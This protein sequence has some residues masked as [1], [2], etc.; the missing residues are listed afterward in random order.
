MREKI[1][2]YIRAKAAVE[3]IG[4]KIAQ[5]LRVFFGQDSNRRL[6]ARL[7]DAG[8]DV[9]APRRAHVAEGALA[10]KTF[11]LTGTL[12]GMTRDAAKAEIE[13]RGGRVASAVSSKTDFLVAGEDAGSKLDKARTLGVPVITAEELQSL[14]AG[15]PLS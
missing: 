7:R 8:V 11:V 1:T 4:P 15:E 5:S 3:G 14:L 13:S 12:T 6:L 9:T 10:G 2:D